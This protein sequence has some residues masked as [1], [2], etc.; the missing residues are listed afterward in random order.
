IRIASLN[1]DTA[2]EPVSVAEASSTLSVN[3]ASAARLAKLSLASSQLLVGTTVISARY[4]VEAFPLMIGLAIRQSV[5]TVAI[6]LIMRLMRKRL[7]EMTRRA[8][9]IVFA[10]ALTGVVLFNALLMLGV[11]RTTATASGIITSTVPAAI[12]LLS[13]AL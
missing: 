6:L 7:P 4:M 1:I 9:L 3:D 2:I 13:F 12:A 8:H 5:A 11:D 10:Q